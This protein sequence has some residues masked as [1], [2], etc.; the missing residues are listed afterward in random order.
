MKQLQSLC[1]KVTLVFTLS[2]LAICGDGQNVIIN[3]PGGGVVLPTLTIDQRNA[4][5]NPTAG[6][7][8]FCTTCGELQVYNGARWTTTMNTETCTQIILCG[9]EWSRSNLSVSTYRNGDPIPQVTDPNVWSSLTTGA[10]CYYNNDPATEVLYG[11]LYNFYAVIDPR[12]LAPTGW[13]IPDLLEW[14]HLRV[15]CLGGSATAGGQMKEPGNTYWLAPN[16]GANN[17]SF[18]S[19]KPGGFRYGGINQFG[20]VSG[21][22]YGRYESATFW[23]STNNWG[24]NTYDPSKKVVDFNLSYQDEALYSSVHG[25]WSL[26]DNLR[27]GRSVRLVHD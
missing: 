24:T 19:A 20:A 18:F 4:I 10:W 16:T 26:Q 22:F 17:S 11:K 25:S 21:T 14:E 8:I 12:G 3:T 27:N 23:T 6:L 7:M 2:V 15:T 1:A 5:A 9:K 13:H